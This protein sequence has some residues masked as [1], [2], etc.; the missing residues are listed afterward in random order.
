MPVVET[1]GKIRRAVLRSGQADQ[2]DLP[3]AEGLS[4]GGPEGAALPVDASSHSGHATRSAARSVACRGPDCGAHRRGR[5][6]A[7]GNKTSSRAGGVLR[8]RNLVMIE[9]IRRA[10]DPAWRERLERQQV[11]ARLGRLFGASVHPL[12]EMPDH[13]RTLRR[14]CGNFALPPMGPLAGVGRQSEVGPMT[15]PRI[16]WSGTPGRCSRPRSRAIRW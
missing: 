2:G 5:S 4:E 7:V 6:P 11:L 13:A 12:E 16:R 3:G 8:L 1:I 14:S 9:N 15:E 10:E